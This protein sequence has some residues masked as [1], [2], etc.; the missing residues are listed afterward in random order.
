M[1]EKHTENEE[2]DETKVEETETAEDSSDHHGHGD[3]KHGHD[4]AHS[5][6][7]KKQAAK[8]APNMLELF[9]DPLVAY[10]RASTVKTSRFVTYAI[11]LFFLGTL[12]GF[13]LP[14][15]A[16]RFFNLKQEGHKN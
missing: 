9:V 15:I 12:F 16:E 8:N 2:T 6:K 3:S 13:F 5:P 4:A 1:V 7:A 11:G 10:I 14:Q